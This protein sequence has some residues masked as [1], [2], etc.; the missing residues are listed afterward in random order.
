[1]R[2]LEDALPVP[3]FCELYSAVYRF[4]LFVEKESGA[5][6]AESNCWAVTPLRI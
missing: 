6:Q 5:G 4:A 3:H 1:M 2:L